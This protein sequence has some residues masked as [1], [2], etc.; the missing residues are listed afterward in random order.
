MFR[1]QSGHIKCSARVIIVINRLF[2]LFNSDEEESR[3]HKKAFSNEL[4]AEVES[5]TTE[6]Q[7][8]Y[9]QI[10]NRD[11]ESSNEQSANEEGKLTAPIVSLGEVNFPLLK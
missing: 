5:H 6:D 3:N 8:N 9:D 2:Y 10:S 7:N 4:G 11:E 1:S